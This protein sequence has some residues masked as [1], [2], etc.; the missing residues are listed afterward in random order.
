MPFSTQICITNTG[1]SPLFGLVK[2]ASNLGD[3]N[4]NNPIYIAQNVPISS[5]TGVNCPYTLSNIPDG[6]TEIRIQDK[7]GCSVR[8]PIL[9]SN[10]CNTCNLDFDSLTQNLISTIN[11]GN[12]TGS[13]DPSITDYRISWYGPNNPNLLAF[14][15]GA[16]NIWPANVN[17]PI[18][19]SSP[20]APF[21]L[22]GTYISRI[23]DVELNGI[24]FSYTGGTNQ[25]ESST[26]TGCS[27]TV[28]VVAY[29]CSNG[30]YSDPYYKHYKSYVTDGTSKPQSLTASFTLSAG[31]PSF[32]W[33]FEA[34]SVYDTLTLTFSGSNYSNPIVLE[35]LRLGSDAGGTNLL[36][37]TFPKRYA[38]SSVFKKVTSLSN[39][40]V[41]DGDNILINITP[42]PANDSTT[43]YL[44][45][46]CYGN[47]TATKT[48]LDS[49]KNR[50]YKIQLSS[51]SATPVG[52][53]GDISFSYKVSGCSTNDNSGYYNSDLYA[54]TSG[55]G[56]TSYI[57]TDN[58]TKLKTV[59]GTFTSS[60]PSISQIDSSL[61]SSCTSSGANTGT[62]TISKTILN[63]IDF[64]F[65]NL[66]DL[67]AFYNSFNSRRNALASGY[68]SDPTNINYYRFFYSTFYT[69]S[70]NYSCGDGITTVNKWYHYSSTATSGTT[71]G[72]YTMTVLTPSIPSNQYVPASCTSN[73]GTT[74][75]YVTEA[76][77]TRTTLF[78]YSN[79]SGLRIQNPF[80]YSR[81]LTEITSPATT[82]FTHQGYLQVYPNYSTDTYPS[83]GVTNTLIPSLSA[84]SWD[85]SN[86]FYTAS[87][88]SQYYYRQFVFHY[89]VR[90]ITFS[91]IV[92]EIWGYA[93]S[94]FNISGSLIKVYD[95][96]TGIGDPT[97]VY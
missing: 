89:E 26:L 32:I 57:N 13:C 43:W 27:D 1:T 31:T 76:N 7:S 71:A 92:Y 67:E 20:D 93:I 90:L 41:N 17:Q 50:P 66:T 30:T 24:K 44:K 88:G 35:N 9:S 42:N 36:P 18:T 54:L 5:I 83:S 38:S 61:P 52:S 81:Q 73:S 68:S 19:P 8:L 65:T 28:N 33:S 25:V 40:V 12:L 84:S 60:K 69:N 64:F 86:H 78:N 62:I 56:D 96:A 91:P 47:P 16:G 46:G 21:L 55:V 3:P 77:N 4:Y 74:N 58:T 14:T 22:P 39:I 53:C 37:T 85:W 11:V 63:Q 97:F 48:C 59:S 94:N 70:G 49:Y 79:T 80:W 45:F 29:N 75:N 51:I 6:T 15:S 23:T 95:S 82:G 10:V 72:G 87:D 2:I 34:L